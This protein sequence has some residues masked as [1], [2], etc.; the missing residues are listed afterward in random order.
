MSGV[1]PNMK[2]VGGLA[3][4]CFRST[5]VVKAKHSA[6]LVCC[7]LAHYENCGCVAP[8]TAVSS[9]PCLFFSM[10]L[11]YSWVAFV[12]GE[13]NFVVRKSVAEL[14]CFLCSLH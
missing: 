9:L 3:K 11:G 7:V 2:C 10:S 13:V 8:S 14:R 6:G 1:F 5:L 4:E 12:L